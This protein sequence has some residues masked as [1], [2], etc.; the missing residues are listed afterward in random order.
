MTRTRVAIVLGVVAV[1]AVLGTAAVAISRYDDDPGRVPTSVDPAGVLTVRDPATGASF[2]VPAA[3]WRVEGPAVRI[4]YTDDHDRPIAE[5]RGP[6]V[7]RAGYCGKGSN[8][9]FA[10]FTHQGLDAWARGVTGA[11]GFASS[12]G[13]E[14]TL[15]DG[16]PGRLTRVELTAEGGGPCVARDVEIAMVE[17]GG[18]SVVLV[19]DVGALPDDVVEQVLLSLELP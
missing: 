15:V 2:E 9:A 19:H 14:V 12:D 1:L 11:D 10:G 6:A 4:Y 8:R 16:S 18:A 7:Y 13:E 3:G 5:V 17:A